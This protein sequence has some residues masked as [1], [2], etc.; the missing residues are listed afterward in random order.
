MDENELIYGGSIV[1]KARLLMAWAPL[2][3]QLEAVASAKTPHEKA[4][5]IIGALRVAANKTTT[6]KDNNVLDRVEEILK[7][8]EG[9]ALVD[10]FI[11][12]AKDV[13]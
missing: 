3:A 5:A 7:T 1:D 2:L 9:M 6:E 4:V 12:F 11:L 8:P 10:W 13:K